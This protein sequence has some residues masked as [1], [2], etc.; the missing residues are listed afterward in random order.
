MGLARFG[1]QSFQP[2]YEG[3]EQDDIA[4]EL[5][6]G[7]GFQPTYEGLELWTTTGWRY[8]SVRFQPTYEGLEPE[9]DPYKEMAAALV[10]S[11][12]MRD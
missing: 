11:L 4:G 3:L 8:N 9:G 5:V 2:T 12:P 6:L 10:F 7:F 1:Q